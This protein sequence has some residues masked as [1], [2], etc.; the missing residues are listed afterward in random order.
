MTKI[1]NFI[2]NHKIITTVLLLIILGVFFFITR[3]PKEVKRDY[4]TASKVNVIQEID[5]TGRVAPAMDVDLAIQSGGKVSDV[6]VVVGQKVNVGQT[7]VRVNTSDL[8]V[9]LARQQA[10]LKK[11]ENILENQEPKTE[12][13]DELEKAYEEGFNTVADTF[14][15]LPS[16]ITGIDAILSH[17][18]ISSNT[19][20]ISYPDVARDYRD[21]AKA[22]YYDAKRMYDDVVKDYKAVTRDS[23]DATVE[24]LILDTYD[25]TKSAAD[26]VKSLNNLIDYVEN[27]MDDEDVP[28][29]LNTDQETLAGFIE[30]TNTHL[31][32]LL[33]IKDTIN[34]SKQ[35]IT[36][37]E[38]DIESIKIDI[39][40]A[41]LDIQD[42]YVQINNRTITAPISGIITDVQAKV[43]ETI[44]QG[45]PVVSL[46]SS[47]QFQIEANLP[48]SDIAKIQLNADADITLDAYGSDEVFKARVVSIDPAETLVEG[49][50]TY[51][52]VLQ[53]IENDDRIKS[54]MTADITIQGDRREGVIAVPQRSVITRDGNKYIQVMEDDEVVEK[55]VKTGLRGTDGNIEITEGV[56]E[57][58]QIVV[59]TE[60][61]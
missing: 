57:G 33:E 49:V 26:A 61:N 23:D 32:A 35:G 21:D 39:E 13:D 55:T 51:K 45:T 5:V 14:L 46:I 47:E 18:Y 28:D 24:S 27:K 29:E 16:I 30:Q 7:L 44:S 43:G 2:K 9:R 8:Q 38:Y 34:D 42:T 36:D 58:D 41:K 59:F 10:E 54:G 53:F 56:S 1:L 31:S 20:A 48:E 40:Q 4:I 6:N 12:A 19:L 52:T 25:A 15:D 22:L 3:E 17:G 50:A 11:A 60:E 37:E